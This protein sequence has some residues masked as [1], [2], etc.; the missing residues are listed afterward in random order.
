LAQ[1][2]HQRRVYGKTVGL[3]LLLESTYERSGKNF[4]RFNFVAC[5]IEGQRKGTMTVTFVHVPLLLLTGLFRCL[6]GN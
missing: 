3:L 4:F 1:F 5:H 6:R 2:V